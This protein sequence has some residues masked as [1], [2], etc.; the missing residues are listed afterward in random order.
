MKKPLFPLQYELPNGQDDFYEFN[1]SKNTQSIGA[2]IQ[3]EDIEDPDTQKLFVATRRATIK[4]VLKWLRIHRNE[5][6]PSTYVVGLTNAECKVIHREEGQE[7]YKLIVLQRPLH[8]TY[9]VDRFLANVNE[10]MQPGGYLY[11]HSLTSAMQREII[12]QKYPKAIGSIVF[13][14]DYI[15]HRIFPKLRLTKKI[16]FYFTKGKKRVFNRVEILGRIY[17]AGFEVIDEGTHNNEF[18]VFCRKVKKP[19]TDIA[20]SGSPII[21]LNRIGKNGKKI[22]VYKF[23]T[24]YSYSE[25]LQPYIYTY[26]KLDSSSKF[27]NDYRVNF[28]G[29][30]LRPIWLDE[31][32]MMINLLKG[33]MKLVGVRPLSQHYFSLY[34]PEMQQLRIKTK[35]GLLPP[36]YYDAKT[37]K[38]IDD[39]QESERRYLEAYLKHPFRTD[40]RYFWGII[41]NII[42]R[43][44]RSH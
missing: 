34:S 44:K 12:R 28:W 1:D 4:V 11:C 8:T 6:S 19:I 27:A 3:A 41:A 20:P 43:H 10:N 16:Y 40:W 21:K 15:W 18:F 33:D 24:M 14:F 17:R 36:F 9:E 25:Y 26:N 32:P 31:L 5:L 2:H 13:A 30:L 39:V 37:P 23:R 35:P 38:N 22:G 7:P 42:F 29:K